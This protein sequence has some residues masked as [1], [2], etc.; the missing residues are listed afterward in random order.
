MFSRRNVVSIPM[1]EKPA[2]PGCLDPERGHDSKTW[3]QCS[4]C[5]TIAVC[6][7]DCKWHILH[8]P[9]EHNHRLAESKKG[10][11]R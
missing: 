11:A 4:G 3:E 9:V 10:A 8:C 5:G 7:P 6:G 2:D 1:P